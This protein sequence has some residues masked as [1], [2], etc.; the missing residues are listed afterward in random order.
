MPR[1]EGPLSVSPDRVGPVEQHEE[2]SLH[3]FPGPIGSD[4]RYQGWDLVGS[5]PRRHP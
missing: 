1:A 5:R 2:P 3:L 4:R